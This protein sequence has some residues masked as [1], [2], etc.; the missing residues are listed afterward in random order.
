MENIRRPRMRLLVVTGA[1]LACVLEA[2]PPLF[3]TDVVMVSVAVEV[4]DGRH[5]RPI[6]FLQAWD[7]IVEENGARRP[8]VACLSDESAPL[9]IVVVLQLNPDLGRDNAPIFARRPF[10]DA[11]DELRAED[12]VSVISFGF[13]PKLALRFC[14]DRFALK[15]AVRQLLRTRAFARNWRLYDALLAALA[16]FPGAPDRGRRRV[17]L[18]LFDR[19]ERGSRAK[20][21][22]VVEAAFEKRAVIFGVKVPDPADPAPPEMHIGSPRGPVATWVIRA[23]E[24]EPPPESVQSLIE[25]TGGELV[26]GMFDRAL[27]LD[28]IDRIRSSYTLYFYAGDTWNPET[29]RTVVVRLSPDAQAR[30]PAAV[31]RGQRLYRVPTPIGDPATR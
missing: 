8:V 6:P 5:G 30:Y 20:P 10:F 28:C 15:L 9:D 1:V 17:V 4:L 21:E 13:R 18:L 14:N 19:G 29:D 24:G 7:F 22:R 16:L 31:V 26:L 27:V 11:L 2:Q 12:R 23:G 3:R 25:Q